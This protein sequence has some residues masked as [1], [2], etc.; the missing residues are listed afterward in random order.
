MWTLVV[1]VSVGLILFFVSIFAFTYWITKRTKQSLTNLH[2]YKAKMSDSPFSPE[3]VDIALDLF[4]KAW[5]KLDS[6][7]KKKLN[8]L[9]NSLVIQWRDR[10]WVVHRI[11]DGKEKAIKVAGEM[12]SSNCIALWIGPKLSNGR[13]KLAYTAIFPALVQ[14]TQFNIYKN[15]NPS[16]AQY[17]ALITD[18]SRQLLALEKTRDVVKAPFPDFGAY[19]NEVERKAGGHPL[20]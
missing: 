1:V 15:E 20:P 6:K 19:S 7:S 14:I 18:L 12:L 11:I 9:L 16:I 3:E 17:K 10:R 5:V 4:Q 13:R 8:K 2:K